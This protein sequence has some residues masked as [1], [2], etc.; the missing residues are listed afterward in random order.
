M[1]QTE[2][3]LGKFDLVRPQHEVHENPAGGNRLTGVSTGRE[4]SAWGARGPHFTNN[5]NYNYGFHKV[6]E[7]SKLP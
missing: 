5:N 7:K 4:V 6:R 2:Q 1:N 3:T